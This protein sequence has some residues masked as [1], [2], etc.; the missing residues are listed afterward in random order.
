[1]GVAVQSSRIERNCA[2]WIR[3]NEDNRRTLLEATARANSTG[4]GKIE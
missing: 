2:W 3:R 4:K 1:M